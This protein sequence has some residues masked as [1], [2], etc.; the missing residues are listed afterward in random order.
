MLKAIAESGDRQGSCYLPRYFDILTLA[1]N[2]LIADSAVKH[3]KLPNLKLQC[4]RFHY[5]LYIDDDFVDIVM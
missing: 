4:K 2:R 5:K 1:H 3:L